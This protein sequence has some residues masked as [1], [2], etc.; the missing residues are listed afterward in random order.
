ME[1]LWRY[2]LPPILAFLDDYE[3]RNKLI[4]MYLLSTLLM[5]VDASLLNRTGAG[6]IF[7]QVSS[8]SHCGSFRS[9]VASQSI[10][11][12]FSALGSDLTPLLLRQ[13]HLTA[14]ELINLL[15]PS[16]P[17]PTSPA[18]L[19]LSKKRHE[20][21]YKL[22]EEG[23]IHPW[24]FKGGVLPIE[25]T[26]LH[27]LPQIL[28]SLSLA[29]VRYF[30]IIVPHL[31]ALIS[32]TPPTMATLDLYALAIGGLLVC[33]EVGAVRMG[34]YRGLIVGAVGKCWVNLKEE[35]DGKSCRREDEG[36]TERLEGLLR[37]LL[38]VLGEKDVVAAKV[39]R[40]NHSR[41]SL[42]EI[43]R[44]SRLIYLDLERS[45]LYSLI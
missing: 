24:E 43:S 8:F 19:V 21:L 31:T 14:L 22:I 42:M 30:Q 32:F 2:I 27:S 29:S 20:A 7:Q 41:R 16:S 12:A 18:S 1:D 10:S 33:F 25:S 44:L 5:Q 11:S 17:L 6:Q 40:S 3:T 9:D 28:Q 13:T 35:E 4:G 26:I 15:Y 34:R 36:R 37:R 23:I 38:I 39:S 45:I